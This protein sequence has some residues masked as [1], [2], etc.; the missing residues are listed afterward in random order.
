MINRRNFVAGTAAVAGLSGLP[1]AAFAEEAGIPEM[2]LGNEEAPVTVIEY[3]SFTCPHCASFHSQV[4][5]DLKSNYIDTGKIKFVMREVYFDRY[6][7]WAS[8]VARCDGTAR[9]FGISDML[10]E[11]QKEWVRGDTPQEIVGNLR[12]I[13]LTAGLTNEQLDVC[14][15][16]GD[17]AKA[18]FDWYNANSKADDV[19]GTPT[20]FI[21]GKK[22]GNMNYED[23]SKTLDE[24]L[25]G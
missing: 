7:L 16:D 8:I 24:Y 10:F 25:A 9:F 17:N 5:K 22:Y 2:V 3:A 4:F 18:L 13:G 1:I 19:T 21:N 12:T 6:G 14:L 20:F 11:Q 15:S 23:F